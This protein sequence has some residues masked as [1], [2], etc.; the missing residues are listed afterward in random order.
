MTTIYYAHVEGSHFD[1]SAVGLS[2]EQAVDAVMSAW[3]S[4]VRATGADPDYIQR[5]DV[6]LLPMLP[7]Q[8]YI[9]QDR[10]AGKRITQTQ[11]KPLSDWHQ[12]VL[13]DHA[14]LRRP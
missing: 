4:H 2:P 9:D 5:D 6:Q 14:R 3:R 10:P 12:T 7:G 11:A 1:F 8:G 13:A